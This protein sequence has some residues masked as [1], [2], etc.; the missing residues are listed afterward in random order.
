LQGEPE[1]ALR[2][3]QDLDGFAHYFR[4]NPVTGQCRNFEML[5][6]FVVTAPLAETRCYGFAAS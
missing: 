1:F 3:A 6:E 4:P 2:G 5:H